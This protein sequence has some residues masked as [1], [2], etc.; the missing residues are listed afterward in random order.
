MAFRI[1]PVLSILFAATAAQ[2]ITN[3][4]GPIN[5]NTTWNAAGSPYYLT[6]DVVVLG[7][8]TLTIDPGVT[9]VFPPNRKIEIQVGHIEAVGTSGSRITFMQ[10][11]HTSGG[12]GVVVYTGST[13][14]GRF[15]YCDFYNL[16]RAV[17][18]SCCPGPP[19]RVR[20]DHSYFRGCT[21]GINGPGLGS[22][23]VAV[24]TTTFESNTTA[25][26]LGGGDYA[27]CVFQSNTTAMDN[28]ASTTVRRCTFESN[29]NAVLAQPGQQTNA[30][31]AFLDSLFQN[32]GIAIQHV[33]RAERCTIVDNQVG[34]RISNPSA[35]IRCNDIYQNANWNAEM[36]TSASIVCD[37]NYWGATLPAQIDV[38]IRDGNDVGTLGYL[39]YIPVLPSSFPLTPCNCTLPVPALMPPLVV[40]KYSGTSVT[41][42]TSFGG[43]G[44]QTYQWYRNGVPLINNGRISGADTLSLTINP[45]Y[46][47]GG[48]PNW[49]DGGIYTCRATNLCGTGDSVPFTL[50]VNNC[51]AD[52]ND[53]GTISSQDLFDFLAAFFTGC[54]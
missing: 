21:E 47:S 10:Q 43:T 14:T 8:A 19:V 18:M 24:N 30:P 54:P 33:D 9:V 12:L 45:I 2:A 31:N 38:G 23:A 22:G 40:T 13:G 52:V 11:N 1:I 17:S 37:N 50:V 15:D 26:F 4:C 41:F 39:F 35:L 49:T 48:D 28:I 7:G 6:C 20:I 44:P 34:L 46:K 5:V 32:N 3:V 51:V 27:D 36:I 25:V 53:S 16:Q 42:S 29:G